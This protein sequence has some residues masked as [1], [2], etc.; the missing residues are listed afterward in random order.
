MEA[1]TADL[2]QRVTEVTREVLESSSLTP[3]G[4]DAVLLVGG[5]SRAPLV[6]RRLEE[7]LGVPVRSDVDPL[8]R[9]GA[10]ARRCSAAHCWSSSP[11]SQ[12]PPSRTCSPCPWAWPSTGGTIRRVFE[13][14]TRLPADKTLV[15]PVTPGPLAL[16]L[17][18]GSSPLATESEYLGALHFQLE[19]AGEAELLFSLSQDGILS[20]FVPLPGAKRSSRSRS[21]P[22][23]WTTLPGT[24]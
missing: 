23:I 15:L 22:R 19:R 11:V 7:S 20:L 1:L 3:Q 6:R 12:A 2:A 16:A 8:E 24:R 18:Q 5:Q 10:A 13:R 17:F 9:R 4:L 21:P 14:N